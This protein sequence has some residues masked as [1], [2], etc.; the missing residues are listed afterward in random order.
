MRD[1]T[2]PRLT[3]ALDA[4]WWRYTWTE[5]PGWR[6][7]GVVTSGHGTGALAVSPTGTYL[8]INDGQGVELNARKVRAAIAAA[9]SKESERAD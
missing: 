7:L 4:P 5:R 2:R 9:A 6:M 8:Q 1:N 3:V